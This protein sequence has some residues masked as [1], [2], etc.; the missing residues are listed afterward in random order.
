MKY[1][2]GL[3]KF[4]KSRIDFGIFVINAESAY[5]NASKEVILN[6]ANTI[7]PKIVRNYLVIL[8]KIDRQSEPNIT[9]KKVKA[10]I[11]N[12]LLNQ[13]N[14]SD[15]I[16]VKLDSRQLKHQTLMKDSFE[17]FLF[18]IFNEYFSKAVIPFK[19]N[20]EG[21]E[22]E[23][24]FN[25]KTFSFLDFL[26]DFVTKGKK[27]NQI[28]EYVEE[29][30][31]K[32]N[33]NYDFGELKINEIYEKIKKQE[34]YKINFGIDLEDE[35]T[36]KIFKCLYMKFKEQDNLPHSDDVNKVLNYF[37]NILENLEK[38]F[39]EIAHRLYNL[40]LK[41]LENNLKILQSSLKYFMKKIKILKL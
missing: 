2:E 27:D 28:E 38:S 36:Q 23:K 7:K 14:L 18:F 8:N 13:L 34:N 4:F 40:F 12:N 33:D 17:H 11:T 39:D 30:E 10:I 1:I 6:V 16:F 31:E 32:F 37:N 26:T 5:A 15:N 20:R 25:T 19:D 41:I 22:E 35:E 9:V 24:K 21:S 3:F 29:L